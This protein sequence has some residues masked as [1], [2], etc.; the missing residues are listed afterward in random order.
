M[1]KEPGSRWKLGMFVIIGLV[2][3]AAAIFFVGRQTNLF[4]S[5][6]R[7]TAQFKSAGGLKEGNNIRFSGINIGTVNTITLKDSFVIVDMVIRK[8]VQEFIKTDA[9]AIIGSDGLM[10]DKV[11]TINP[12]TISK[13]HVKDGDQILTKKAI[14][15][16]DI[17]ASLKTNV[18]NAGIIT[19]QLADFTF[20]MN[21][22][23]GILSKVIGDET[24][25]KSLQSTLANLQN[26]SKQFSQFSVSMNSGK[27]A[28]GL[29]SD[30][31]FSDGIKQTATNL[32]NTSAQFAL[33]STKM[34]EGNGTISQLVTDDKIGKS[35]DSTMYNI[36]QATKK[37]D[38]N[39]EALQHNFLL[40]GFF[41][42]K[43]KA[44]AK[45]AIEVKRAAD[46]Q[47]KTDAPITEQGKNK[48]SGY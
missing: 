32:Q 44:D 12:G 14:D 6:F 31:N 22:G 9:T 29:V 37:L 16:D 1:S 33:F 38:E 36:Q 21:N 10:G 23:D 42:K 28:L 39:M 19:A 27:G 8:K 15:M 17:M 25:S 4:G 7:L 18:D 47:I 20:K 35:L 45:K 30:E 5:T 13:T 24:L 41:K 34:N 26:T 48:T 2:V 3:F 11:L 43:A 40:K 46:L